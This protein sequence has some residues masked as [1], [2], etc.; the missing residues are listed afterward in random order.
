MKNIH[1]NVIVLSL[2]VL[3]SMDCCSMDNESVSNEPESRLRSASYE[4]GCNGDFEKTVT[5]YSKDCEYE[6]FKGRPGYNSLVNAV[7][8][9]D[10]CKEKEIAE[11]LKERDARKK[12]NIK[13]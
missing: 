13:S 7:I 2:M 1:V 3:N 9:G 8:N 6:I 11:K 12:S 5:L 4:A 10:A